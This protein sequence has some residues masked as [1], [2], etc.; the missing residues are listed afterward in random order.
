MVLV[1]E[2]EF[3]K[4]LPSDLVNCVPGNPDDRFLI[5]D[6]LKILLPTV[7]D[8]LTDGLA[9]ESGQTPMPLRKWLADGNRLA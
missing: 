7:V 6:A 8:E 1:M 9:T 2:E 4:L 3:E 5:S